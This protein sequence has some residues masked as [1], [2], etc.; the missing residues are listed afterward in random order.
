MDEAARV[1]GAHQP[2]AD[3]MAGL[4]GVGV[5]G[6]SGDAFKLRFEAAVVRAL[7]TPST[8]SRA[9]AGAGIADWALPPEWAL[10][11][12]IAD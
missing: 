9:A 1:E 3:A 11:A 5:V 8:P 10:Y 7:V 4:A 2:A 6:G 12:G